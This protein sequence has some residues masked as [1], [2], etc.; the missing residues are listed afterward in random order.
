M[1]RQVSISS[2]ARQSAFRVAFREAA[3]LAP[4][5]ILLVGCF[6]I[7]LLLIFWS[8][9]FGGRLDFTNYARLLSEPLY[10]RTTLRTFEVGFYVT[11]ICLVFG[12]PLAYL[13]TIV[14]SATRTSLI[15]LI[16]IPLFTAFLIRTY[17]WIIIL[18]RQG[19]V[20]LVLMHLGVIGEPLEIL[21]T[22]AAVYIG[23]SHVLMPIAIFTMYSTMNQIDRNLVR[24]AHV[25]GASPVRAFLRV[26][27]PLT[28][29]GVLAAGVL[30]FIMSIG[31]YITPALLGGPSETMISQLIVT[32]ATTLLNLEMSF[33]LAVLLLAATFLVLA[34]A[35]LVIPIELMWSVPGAAAKS[36]DRGATRV[37]QLLRGSLAAAAGHRVERIL[38]SAGKSTT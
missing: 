22:P 17:A 12:Y 28:L 36:L 34:L 33:S 29:P 24:A 11:L 27:F 7:P 37:H 20:N 19:I 21:H 4:A 15:T 18:G 9:F 2:N 30:V 8:S 14:G 26:Y 16:L 35:G 5:G 1:A 25:L 6:L 10:F 23:M 31:F 38:D 3:L 32:Q 13:L